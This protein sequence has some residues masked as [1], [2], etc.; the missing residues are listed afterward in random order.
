MP[1][2]DQVGNLNNIAGLVDAGKT[3]VDG[4]TLLLE[5]FVYILKPLSLRV[6]SD[7]KKEVGR[8]GYQRANPPDQNN[9]PGFLCFSLASFSGLDSFFL[10][11][12]ISA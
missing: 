2:I 9:G 6:D 11:M 10:V 8:N 4:I 3:M 7:S 12:K 5:K 1:A